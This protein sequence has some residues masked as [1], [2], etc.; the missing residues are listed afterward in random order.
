VYMSPEQLRAASDVD[1]RTDVWSLGIIL[2]EL[3]A[4]QPPFGG[5]VTQAIASIVQDAPPVLTKLRPE[6]P[7]DL[8]RVIRRALEKHP[9]RRYADVVSFAQAIVPFASTRGAEQL[10]T[11][12]AMPLEPVS[13]PISKRPGALPE[14]D[15]HAQTVAAFRAEG[16]ETQPSWSSAAFASLRPHRRRWAFLVG[17]ASAAFVI[18]AALLGVQRARR[19]PSSSVASVGV[20]ARIATPAPQ[21]PDEPSVAPALQSGPS[22]SPSSTAVAPARRKNQ[23]PR[24]ATPPSRATTNPLHL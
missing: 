21:P 18:A 14:G 11:A 15:R 6:V 23:T 3:L 7:A 5:A 17:A 8:E 12:L 20:S 1:A 22:A 9:T 4:G 13:S 2:F 19:T 10:R 16:R 24:T